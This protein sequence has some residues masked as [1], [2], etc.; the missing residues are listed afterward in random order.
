MIGTGHWWTQIIEQQTK[1]RREGQGLKRKAGKREPKST[2][3]CALAQKIFAR[4]RELES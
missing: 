3:R 2:I 1:E 4:S